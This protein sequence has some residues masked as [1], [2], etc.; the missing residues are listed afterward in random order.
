[1]LKAA[2]FCQQALTVRFPYSRLHPT[3]A[4]HSPVI[5]D[6][7]CRSDLQFSIA[8]FVRSGKPRRWSCDSHGLLNIGTSSPLA[9]EQTKSSEGQMS[10][11]MNNFGPITLAYFPY[12]A[13]LD[14]I[15]VIAGP[16]TNT[17]RNNGFALKVDTA[18]S[19]RS[20]TSGGI[21]Y[22]TTGVSPLSSDW[23]AYVGYL[24]P[25]TTASVT[26]NE[27]AFAAAFH[28]VIHLKDSMTWMGT[29]LPL[30]GHAISFCKAYRARQRHS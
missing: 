20:L 8:L 2:S 29:V 28:P 3:L 7:A 12:T 24:S 10:W 26:T 5:S 17:M 16:S 4:Q 14:T 23:A 9:I 15:S 6:F 25:V 19:S 21:G 11:S 13:S 22:S 30:G 27:A 18:I 1:M